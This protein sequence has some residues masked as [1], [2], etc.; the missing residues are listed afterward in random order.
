MRES[1]YT[2]VYAT[3]TSTLINKVKG[4]QKEGWVCAHGFAVVRGGEFFQ[5]MVRIEVPDEQAKSGDA[6]GGVRTPKVQSGGVIP[7]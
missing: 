1:D 7:Q 5:P 3:L 4:L 6:G 2:V